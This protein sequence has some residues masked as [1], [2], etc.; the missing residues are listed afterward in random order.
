MTKKLLILFLTLILTIGSVGCSKVE[1]QASSDDTTSNNTETEFVYDKDDEMSSKDSQSSSS[2]DLTLSKKDLNDSYDETEAGT[3]TFSGS[4]VTVSGDGLSVSGSTVTIKSEGTYILSGNG[5]GQVVVSLEDEDG[6][7][8]LVLN[9]LTLS[10]SNGA[11]I[12]VTDADKVIIT[13]PE[14]TEST[15]SDGTSYSE[16]VDS[17]EVDAAIFSKEDLTI[18][19][20]GTLNVNGNYAHGIVSKDDLVVYETTVNVEAVK[21]ALRGKDSVVLVDCSINA[22]A[23]TKGLESDN[24][25]DDGKGYIYVEN[26]SVTVVSGTKGILAENYIYLLS[27][28][29]KVTSSDDAIHCNNTIQIDNASLTLS[30]GD[31]GIHADNVI[32]INGGDIKITKSYEG[33]EAEVITVNGGNIDITSSDDGFNAGGNSSTTDSYQYHNAMMDTDSNAVLT[34]NDGY[35]HVN[36]QGDGLDSNGYLYIK[37][38][39]V[40]VCGPSG[41]GNGSLDWGISGSITGGTLIALGSSGMNEK[42][43][44]VTQG[45]IITDISQQ[46]ASALVEIVDSNGKTILSYTSEKTFSNVTVSSSLIEKGSTYSINVNGKTVTTITMSDLQYYNASGMGQGMGNSQPGGFRR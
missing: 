37:G 46:S 19:G 12:L 28:T 17:T 10:N 22:K 27:G 25:E 24:D 9:N 40:Y 13:V 21:T 1:P 30:S 39:T 43:S 18:N 8:Q 14:S 34:I 38:G 45:T 44:S 7:V 11:A 6:K 23:G 41:S 31:D 16:T 26:S 3:I 36:A 35:I 4:N 20:K 29:V 33:I 5:N 32:V 42:I 2:Y 15:I